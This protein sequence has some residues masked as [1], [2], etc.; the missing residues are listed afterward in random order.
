MESR[1]H[2]S[3]SVQLSA[4]ER[5]PQR[6]REVLREAFTDRLKAIVLYDLLTVVTELVQNGIQ[7]GEGD[8]VGLSVRL[9]DSSLRGEVTSDGP[10]RVEPG[11]VDHSAGRGL[12][13]HI[14]DA[15][16]D[17]WMAHSNGRTTVAFEMSTA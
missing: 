5:S 1:Q 10:G 8:E 16:T 15:L 17:R 3:V 12:G 2:V 13:L 6:A 9:V 14:V 7:H 11:P 4:D